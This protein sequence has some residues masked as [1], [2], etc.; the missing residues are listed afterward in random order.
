MLQQSDPSNVNAPLPEQLNMLQD[1]P[2]KD[3]V[4]KNVAFIAYEFTIEDFKNDS[5]EVLL[6]PATNNERRKRR[7]VTISLIG[8][9]AY[10][11]IQRNEAE[12]NVSI[13]L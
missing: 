12:N 8:N 9:A 13:L 3:K 6:K 7:D 1:S 11:I 2:P 5:I 4:A 10:R